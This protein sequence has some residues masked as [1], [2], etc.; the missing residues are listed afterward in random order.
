MK[1]IFNF[2]VFLLFDLNSVVPQDCMKRQISCDMNL[3]MA[4]HRI[5]DNREKDVKLTVECCGE[6]LWTECM[7]IA[8]KESQYSSDCSEQNKVLSLKRTNLTKRVECQDFKMDSFLCFWPQWTFFV[9]FLTAFA[10]ILC[11][12]AIAILAVQPKIPTPNVVPEAVEPIAPPKPDP[13][14]NK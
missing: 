8:I 4:K 11:L 9:V 6:L 14:K 3:E 12:A 10:M 7:R 2:V 5:R 13:I 1:R